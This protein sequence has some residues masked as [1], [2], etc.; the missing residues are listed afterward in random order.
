MILF[1]NKYNVV[2]P[3]DLC[4]VHILSKQ[5]RERCEVKKKYN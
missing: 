2:E 1:N 4:A 3:Y 5:G